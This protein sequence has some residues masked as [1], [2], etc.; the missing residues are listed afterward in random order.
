M[1][2]DQDL[3]QTLSGVSTA[4]ITTILLKKACA[5]S[6]CVVAAPYALAYRGWLDLPSRCASFLCAKTSQHQ[7]RGHHRGQPGLPSKLWRKVVL[8]WSMRWELPMPA[9]TATFCAP[10]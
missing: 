7:N 1:K 10:A 2:P 8:P 6:G 3:V 4:T 5:T 9:F